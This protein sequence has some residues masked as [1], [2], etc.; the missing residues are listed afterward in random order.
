VL[1]V[2]HVLV[3]VVQ[4]VAGA[5]GGQSPRGAACGL[6]SQQTGGALLQGGSD[7]FQAVVIEIIMLVVI[8]KIKTKHPCI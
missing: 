1:C 5:P 8:T 2:H 6:H 4:R 3:Q 7:V